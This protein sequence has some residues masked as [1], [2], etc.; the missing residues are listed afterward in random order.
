MKERKAS[1]I[2]RREDGTGTGHSIKEEIMLIEDDDLPRVAPAHLDA[3]DP[4]CE[5]PDD[6]D[7]VESS[8]IEATHGRPARRSD[9]D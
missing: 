7:T 5:M 6:D 9:L 4:D 8:E 1:E 3:T 2:K